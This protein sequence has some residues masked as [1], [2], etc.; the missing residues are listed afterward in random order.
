MRV[1]AAVGNTGP[2]AGEATL[3][4]FIRDPVATVV[5]PRLELRG[6]AKLM[7]GPGESGT[8]SFTLAAKDI[9]Y[10]RDGYDPVLEPGA[11]DI[12]VGQSAAPDDLLSIRVRVEAAMS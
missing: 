4:L 1:T 10:P 11:L 7:L 3:F 6:V 2:R 8:V 5:R 12:L 9:G